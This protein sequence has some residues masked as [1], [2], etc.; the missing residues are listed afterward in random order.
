MSESFAVSSTSV[1][2]SGSTSGTCLKTGPYYSSRNKSIIVFVAQGQ[3]FPVDPVDGRSTT[4][5]MVNS[6]TKQAT[7]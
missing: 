1:S 4:W 3:K 2:A 7:I 5:Y 6:A